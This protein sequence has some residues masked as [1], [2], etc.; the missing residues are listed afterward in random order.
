MSGLSYA[1]VSSQQMFTEFRG[2]GTYQA[3]FDVHFP[4]LTMRETLELAAKAR[5]TKKDWDA[6]HIDVETEARTL[7]LA[8][9]LDTK[10]GNE[11]LPGV[12]GGE[13]KRTSIAVLVTQPERN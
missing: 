2:K 10:M 9:A 5:S 4:T 1:G 7:G 3:E 13:R 8:K 11:L 12:S 6:C